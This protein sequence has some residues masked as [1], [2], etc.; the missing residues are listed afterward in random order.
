VVLA[1]RWP[2]PAPLLATTGWQ[3]VAGGL[4]VAPVA[5]AVE[6]P[7][8]A[9]LTAAN[10]AGYAYLTAVGAALAYALWFRGIRA[11]SPSHVTFLA[12]LSPVVATALGWIALGQTLTP[13]QALG[14]LIVLGS[15]T[16]AQLSPLSVPT[17]PEAIP[18]AP[19]QR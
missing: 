8:P 12:L 4:L 2:S 9:T 13:V 5:L 10:L 14:A 17:T 19:P 15:V 3:L 6:G 16:V 1:K 7:P 11:L 18:W